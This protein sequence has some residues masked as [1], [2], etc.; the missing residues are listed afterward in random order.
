MAAKRDSRST[1]RKRRPSRFKQ[2]ENRSPEKGFDSEQFFDD[3]P[4]DVDADPT[5][6]EFWRG[7]GEHELEH[8]SLDEDTVTGSFLMRETR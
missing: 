6:E 7:I 3:R 5:L 1:A 2:S 4:A 8:D